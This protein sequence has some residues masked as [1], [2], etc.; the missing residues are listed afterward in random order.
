MA[1]DNKRIPLSWAISR[2]LTA[3]EAGRPFQSETDKKDDEEAADALRQWLK[4]EWERTK[5]RRINKH[6]ESSI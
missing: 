2:G 6:D 3:L 5:L 1:T 4:R